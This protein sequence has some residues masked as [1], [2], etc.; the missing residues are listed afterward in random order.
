MM[1][2]AF[3]LSCPPRRVQKDASCTVSI[4]SLIPAA[5]QILLSCAT[6]CAAMTPSDR[7]AIK[8]MYRRSAAEDSVHVV[9]NLTC[10]WYRAAGCDV[11]AH[12]QALF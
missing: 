5:K 6:R 1:S 2:F 9:C 4:E 7:E 3:I 12:A 10:T 11:G 8:A